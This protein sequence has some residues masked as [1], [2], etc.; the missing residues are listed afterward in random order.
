MRT[1]QTSWQPRGLLRLLG[2]IPA[3]EMPSGCLKDS[4]GTWV[5]VTDVYPEP[6]TLV[7]LAIAD[8]SVRDQVI[9]LK[10]HNQNTK[11]HSLF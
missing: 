5:K 7:I 3:T 9:G 8:D 2:W 4:L 6:G 11:G 10:S 1:G